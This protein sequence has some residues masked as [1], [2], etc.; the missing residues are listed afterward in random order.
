MAAAASASE[1]ERRERPGGT[2]ESCVTSDLITRGS[3]ALSD[4]SFG[5]GGV[6]YWLESRPS[7]RGRT[8]VVARAPGSSSSSSSSSS[9]PPPA[10]VDITP[11]LPGGEEERGA[12]FFNVRTRVHEYGGGALCVIPGDGS[13]T[14]LFSNFADQRLYV[15]KVSLDGSGAKVSAS[16]PRALTPE[17]PP[18]SSALLRF[19]D[20][21]PDP[22][23]PHERV[24]VVLEDHSGPPSPNEPEN[25]LATVSLRTGEVVKIA[26]GSDFY[27]SPRPSPDG[28]RIAWVE[29]VREFFFLFGGVWRREK[30]ERE[31]EKRRKKTKKKSHS[32]PPSPSP[33]PHASLFLTK[34]NAPPTKNIPDSQEHPNMPWDDTTLVVA[35][36]VRSSG[37]DGEVVVSVDQSS[38]RV[39][40]G[41]PGKGD[42]AMEP[43]WFSSEGEEDFRLAF[44]SDETGWWNVYAEG[45]GGGEKRNSFFFCFSFFFLVEKEEKKPSHSLFHFFSSDSAS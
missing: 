32:R 17:A 19:A 26:R 28:K 7:E 25:C 20:A 37:E 9:S 33:Y 22:L 42:S 30:R 36:L 11:P 16:A 27:S 14:V 43:V 34:K 31:R 35:D 6:L 4:P 21:E 45:K 3:K 13:D 39:V 23:A 44:I 10:A 12:P 8:V 18:P 41:G 1:G 29:W 2:W 5:S 40:A 38:R 15:Q 24:F